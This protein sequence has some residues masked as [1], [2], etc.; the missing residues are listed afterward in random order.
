MMLLLA[1]LDS[2]QMSSMLYHF[3]TMEEVSIFIQLHMHLINPSSH[4]DNVDSLLITG[5]TLARYCNPPMPQAVTLQS[6]D[7]LKPADRDDKFDSTY[8]YA[9]SPNLAL[10]LYVDNDEAGRIYFYYEV[11]FSQPSLHYLMNVKDNHFPNHSSLPEKM[12]SIASDRTTNSNQLQLAVPDRYPVYETPVPFIDNFTPETSL[13]P[14]DRKH[15][16]TNL[17]VLNL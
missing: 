6:P 1:V 3:L 2:S 13:A 9:K 15:G 17:Y 5:S 11:S 14:P 10:V 7:S 4:I 12:V 16:K 8:N